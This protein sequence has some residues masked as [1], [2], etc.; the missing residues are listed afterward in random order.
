M[1]VGERKRKK[2]EEKDEGEPMEEDDWEEPLQKLI[3]KEVQL[4]KKEGEWEAI[5]IRPPQWK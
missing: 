2:R 1:S 4:S 3:K 5:P